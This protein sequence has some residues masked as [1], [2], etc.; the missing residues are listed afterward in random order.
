MTSRTMRNPFSPPR[1]GMQRFQTNQRNHMIHS[2]FFKRKLDAGLR[3]L[4]RIAMAPMLAAEMVFQ[5][6]FRA[7]RQILP[8]QAAVTDEL[9]RLFQHH[10]KEAVAVRT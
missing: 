2:G 8:D 9:A 6:K 3:C 10:T 5:L 4:R 7:A 1:D